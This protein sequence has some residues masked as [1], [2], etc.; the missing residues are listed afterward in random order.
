[1]IQFDFPEG[2]AELYDRV[3]EDLKAAGHE[4]PKGLLYHV[5]APKPSGGWLVVDVWESEQAFQ[6]FGQTLLPIIQKHGI[7]QVQPAV[8]P[9]HN[10]YEGQTANALR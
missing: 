3:W 5:G 6:E 1:M 2:T 8:F 10:I 4:N 7:P 9:V